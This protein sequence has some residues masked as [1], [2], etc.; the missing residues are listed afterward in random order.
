MSHNEWEHGKQLTIHNATKEQLQWMVK[1][2]EETIKRLY[3]QIEEERR[4]HEK[5][6]SFYREAIRA[7]DDCKA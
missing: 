2:R 1:D 6:I 4:G 3:N 5:M 7:K